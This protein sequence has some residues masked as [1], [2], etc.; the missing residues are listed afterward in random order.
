LLV[1]FFLTSPDFVLSYPQRVSHSNDLPSANRL[2]SRQGLTP[3][4]FSWSMILENI[5]WP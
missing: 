5:R 3:S 4:T 2:V 1:S